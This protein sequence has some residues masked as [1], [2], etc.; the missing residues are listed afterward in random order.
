MDRNDASGAAADEPTDASR[1][2]F[3]ARFDSRFDELRL[4]L[5]AEPDVIGVTFADKLPR[6]YHGW[7][8]IEVDEGAI[9]PWHERGHHAGVASIDVDYFDVLGTP[10]VSGRRFHAGDV[11]SGARVVI[12]NQPFVDQVL[13][14]RNPVGRRLRYITSEFSK[15]P[16][17]DGPWYEIVGV[18]RDLGT[19]S[20]FG[21]AGI[22]HPM[23]QGEVTD[24]SARES[25]YPI[26]LAIHAKGDPLSFVPRLRAIATSVDPTLRLHEPIRLDQVVDEELRFYSFWFRLAVL[27]SSVALLLSLAGIYAVMAF[28]VARRTR[29]IGIRVALGAGARGVALAVFRRPLAQVAL[30]ILLGGLATGALSYGVLRESIWPGGAA[31]V[32]AYA[33]LMLAVCLLACIV[34]TRRALRIQPTEALRDG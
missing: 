33:A 24:G 19:K 7:N 31:L 22:Y 11:A 17:H 29:E 2:A 9:S 20:G 3:M 6:M 25:G 16:R 12:V 30:G 10:V 27:M 1:A 34:P 13:G 28:T 26:Y 21:L 4:R 23:T 15:Q 14:G 18:A 8:R 5:A 32:A